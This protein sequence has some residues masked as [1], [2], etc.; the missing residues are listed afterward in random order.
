[1]S[2]NVV[3]IGEYAFACCPSLKDIVL[4]QKLE[5]VHNNAFWN[6]SSFEKMQIPDEVRFIG[7]EV[8][9]GCKNLKE[10]TISKNIERIGADTFAGCDKIEAINYNCTPTELANVNIGASMNN[11]Y[12][13]KINFLEKEIS[14]EF[15][16]GVYRD[17]IDDEFEM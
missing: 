7:N 4:S 1:M 8:L 13:Q 16:D 15:D 10:V 12:M 2:N 17:E 5:V 11:S 3:K 14:N 6:C 9:S